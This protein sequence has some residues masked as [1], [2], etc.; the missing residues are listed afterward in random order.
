M[1]DMFSK[2]LRKSLSWG[3]KL[4]P[5]RMESAN[6]ALAALPIPWRFL[7]DACGIGDSDEPVLPSKASGID[8]EIRRI[9]N[10][11]RFRLSLC[12]EAASTDK[13]I[14]RFG[15]VIEP[16][17]ILAGLKFAPVNA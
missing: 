17:Q 1:A 8:S 12:L 3:K 16:V 7:L 9:S 15:F 11:A 4:E 5:G 10:I 2:D 13:N 14:W 6:R